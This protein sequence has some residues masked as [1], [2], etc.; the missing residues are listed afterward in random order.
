[1]LYC[2]AEGD[3]CA[4]GFPFE[5]HSD[6]LHRVNGVIARASQSRRCCKGKM[7][8][9]SLCRAGL[10]RAIEGPHLPNSGQLNSL[11]WM[12]PERLLGEVSICKLHSLPFKA[13]CKDVKLTQLG[14]YP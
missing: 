4:L 10:S 12:P 1:M 8:M 2:G 5:M 3:S 9:T 6:V 11:E 13:L 7:C 14:P